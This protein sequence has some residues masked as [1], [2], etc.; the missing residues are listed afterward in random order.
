MISLEPLQPGP[1]SVCPISFQ[2]VGTGDTARA[3]SR[4][5]AATMGF[6]TSTRGSASA[7]PAGLGTAVMLVRAVPSRHALF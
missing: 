5:V 1:P 7:A 3:V 6:V 2:S 4:T